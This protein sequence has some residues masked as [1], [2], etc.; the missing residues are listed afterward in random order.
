MDK[1]KLQK[2]FN[3]KRK[4]LNVAYKNYLECKKEYNRTLKE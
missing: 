1:T 4:E 2:E 3:K